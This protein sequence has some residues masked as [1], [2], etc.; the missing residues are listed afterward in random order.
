[1]K[2]LYQIYILILFFIFLGCN[3][4]PQPIDYGS[5]ACHFCK[6]NIVDK[7]HASEIVTKKGKAYKFDST[8]CMLNFLEEFDNTT[9]ALY[10]SND[11]SNPEKLIDATKATFLIS[12]Q[13]PSPMGANLSAFK[14]NANAIK[15]QKEKG[16][17]LYTWDELLNYFK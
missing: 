15:M 16:G 12:E 2:L 11:Y 4:S 5:D 1:M 3:V 10:L 17:E 9:I 8:E 13:I 7:Q 6:M 14:N